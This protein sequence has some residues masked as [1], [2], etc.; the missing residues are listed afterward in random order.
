MKFYNTGSSTRCPPS[1]F[2]FFCYFFPR[3]CTIILDLDYDFERFLK[4]Q[5]LLFFHPR[6]QALS[7]SSG[8]I[9][10]MKSDSSS[11]IDSSSENTYSSS[12]ENSDNVT[13]YRWQ[14]VGKKI[15]KSKVDVTFKDAAEM[16]TDDIKILKEHIYIERR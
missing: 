6:T 3:R 1:I 14:I 15:N 9:D 4:L 13:F 12:G 7:K 11:D 8:T 5:Q 16:F 10:D 2:F